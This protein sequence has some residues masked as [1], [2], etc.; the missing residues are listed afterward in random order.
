MGTKHT[1]KDQK[2]SWEEVGD[3]QRTLNGYCSM[4]IKVLRMGDYW[5]YSDRICEACTQKSEKIPPMK[6][7]IKDHKEVRGTP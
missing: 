3:L 4:W 2:I 6:L 7:L 5:G 1:C